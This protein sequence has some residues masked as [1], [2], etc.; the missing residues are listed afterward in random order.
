MEKKRY[1]TRDSEE[2]GGNFCLWESPVPPTLHKEG[3]WVT[4]GNVSRL[5]YEMKHKTG[6]QIILILIKA[7]HLPAVGYG[8]CEEIKGVKK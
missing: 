8:Q 3:F 5:H 2:Y 4:E 6:T 7:G 1:L